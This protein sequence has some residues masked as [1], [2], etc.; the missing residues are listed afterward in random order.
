MIKIYLCDDDPSVLS[1]YQRLIEETL[2]TK[3]VPVEIKTF[4]SGESLLFEALENPNEVGIIFL[5][6]QMKK[7]TGIDTAKELRKA[8]CFAEII[9]LTSNREMV[10]DSFDT[11]PFHYLIKADVTD[12]KF[13][14]VLC[15]AVEVAMQKEKNF[16]LCSRGGVKKKIPLHSISH[17]SINGRIA[18]VYYGTSSFEFY[19]RIDALQQE[20]QGKG[21]VRCHRSVLVNLH[22]VEEIQKDELT[23]VNGTVLPMGPS[24]VKELKEAF[25]EYLNDTRS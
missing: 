16:F 6:M 13:C 15:K 22:F 8:G 21:F 3:A 1:R 18:T 14:E 9:Y 7:I 5:D 17:F 24:Y 25:F 12:E 4:A 2:K 11:T 10:F 20:L 23:L 19:G